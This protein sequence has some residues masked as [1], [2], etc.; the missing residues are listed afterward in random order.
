MKSEAASNTLV[1]IKVLYDNVILKRFGYKY[2][3]TGR[4]NIIT[5]CWLSNYTLA[6][7][8]VPGGWWNIYCQTADYKTVSI[9]KNLPRLVKCCAEHFSKHCRPSLADRRRTMWLDSRQ[10]PTSPLPTSLTSHWRHRVSYFVAAWLALQ[11]RRQ[12]Q[13]HSAYYFW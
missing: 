11:I 10:F 12:N 6:S 7:L 1:Y 2:S 9:D 4:D 3:S 8:S 13:R 5:L